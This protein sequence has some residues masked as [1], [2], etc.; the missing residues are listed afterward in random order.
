MTKRYGSALALLLLIAAPALGQEQPAPSKLPRL[1]S[2][3]GT[4]TVQ[5]QP[6][7]AVLTVAVESRA[8]TAQEAAQANARKMDAV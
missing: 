1:L 3:S 6:D 7:R 8:A 5:R 4:G 2:V